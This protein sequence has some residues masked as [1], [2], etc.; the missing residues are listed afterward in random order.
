MA[1]AMDAMDV[2]ASEPPISDDKAGLPS[3]DQSQ[4]DQQP[5]CSTGDIPISNNAEAAGKERHTSRQRQRRGLDPGTFLLAGAGCLVATLV[6]GFLRQ[7][8]ELLETCRQ[9][10]SAQAQLAVKEQALQRTEEQRKLEQE[11]R[12]THL[13]QQV[14]DAQRELTSAHDLCR[15]AATRLEQSMSDLSVTETELRAARTQLNTASRD[16]ALTRAQL[17]ATEGELGVTR[18][19]NELM[20]REIDTLRRQLREAG[21]QLEGY[22]MASRQRK[23]GLGDMDGMGVGG[24]FTSEEDDVA[25]GGL[26]GWDTY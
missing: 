20:K 13:N 11:G 5:Q 2:T 18:S 10:R 7:Q 19:A 22:I 3:A 16:L 15:Q 25:A 21:Q 14:T 9:L 8:R 4:G 1:M 6:R 17:D 12:M 24:R 26:G 23:N